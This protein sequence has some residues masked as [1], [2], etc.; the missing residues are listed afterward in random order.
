MRAGIYV[1]MSGIGLHVQAVIEHGRTLQ[2]SLIY[3]A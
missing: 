2:Q 3:R 1:G